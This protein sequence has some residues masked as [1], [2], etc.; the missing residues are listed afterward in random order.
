M[1]LWQ[2]ISSPLKKI[3]LVWRKLFF[4]STLMHVSALLFFIIVSMPRSQASLFVV[5]NRMFDKHAVLF[6]AALSAPMPAIN[7]ATAVPSPGIEVTQ[8]VSDEP[9]E[10]PAV[11]YCPTPAKKASEKVAVTDKKKISEKKEASVKKASEKPAAP[12]KVVTQAQKPEKVAVSKQKISAAQHAS[13]VASASVR[14]QPVD[15]AAVIEIPAFMR[16]E[17]SLQQYNMLQRQLATQWNAPPGVDATCSCQIKFTLDHHGRVVDSSV[18]A[19]SGLLLYD[20]AARYA[21]SAI[22]LPHWAWGKSFIVTFKQ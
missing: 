10:K 17:L 6:T 21:L 16:G 13:T 7:K 11:A 18:H 22:E 5:D 1:L 2:C 19:S 20:M 15:A 8:E 3:S 9:V 4:V 14:A 12:T